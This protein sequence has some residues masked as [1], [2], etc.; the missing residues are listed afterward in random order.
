M[1]K[2]RKQRLLEKKQQ[3]H[4]PLFG[5]CQGFEQIVLSETDFG[6]ELLWDYFEGTDDVV[7]PLN[8]TQYAAKS[9]ML[10]SS[11]IVELNKIVKDTLGNPQNPIAPYY[12][13]CGILA[14]DF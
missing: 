11:S 3:K 12:H 9:R 8:Y 1:R 4:F 7:L 6:D 5:I 2:E 13:S 14:F 10:N